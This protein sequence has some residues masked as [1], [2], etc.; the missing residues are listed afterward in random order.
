MKIAFCCQDEGYA[1]VFRKS[2]VHL[3]CDLARREAWVL[4][5]WWKTYMIE[6]PNPR[7]D[8]DARRGWLIV[9]V[10]NYLDIRLVSF[11]RNIRGASSRSHCVK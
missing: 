4:F 9:K 3:Q 7:R 11:A 10:D 6:E 5:C 2:V 8:F 1:A